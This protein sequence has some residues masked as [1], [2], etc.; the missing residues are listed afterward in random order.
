MFTKI[1]DAVTGQAKF[2][3]ADPGSDPMNEPARKDNKPTFGCFFWVFI[4]SL[5]IGVFFF[6][7]GY[8]KTKEQETQ[9][10]IAT[11]VKA[12]EDTFTKTPTITSTPS[13]TFTLGPTITKTPTVTTTPATATETPTP[14][15]T[16]QPK[17]IYQNNT[18]VITVQVPWVIT[19]I[20]KQTVIVVVT[21][22][23]TPT[24]SITFTP[25]ETPTPT[26]TPTETP[27]PT[28]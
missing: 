24:P 8:Q 18:I 6:V 9:N 2:T 7:R 15:L 22:T 1:I 21:A 13:L 27:T 17:I 14:T 4:I 12:T 11:S 5:V 3:R 10:A 23:E 16:P 28:P 25:S 26:E 19:Q 20:V